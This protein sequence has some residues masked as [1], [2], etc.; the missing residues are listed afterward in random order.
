MTIKSKMLAAMKRNE[1]RMQI[2][3]TQINSCQLSNTKATVTCLIKPNV[4][5]RKN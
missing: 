5:S 2:S 4:K 3:L 1:R